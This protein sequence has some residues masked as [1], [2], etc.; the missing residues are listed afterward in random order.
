MNCM[1][2]LSVLVLASGLCATPVLAEGTFSTV[3]MTPEVAV[4]LAQE[5]LK[6]C[7]AKG[8]QVAVAV[9]DRGGNTQALIRDRF[10]GPHT[11][12]TATRKA[13]TAVSFRANTTD[14]AARTQPGMESSGTRAIPKILMLGGGVMVETG[15][16]LIGAVGVSGAPSGAEDEGCAKVG[17]DA[18]IADLEF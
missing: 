13:Y 17:I 10:A 1:K 8:Y 14:L 5:T 18:I 3:S 4:K 2:S 6:A 16:S 11:P 7:R 9:L 12:E 15:G